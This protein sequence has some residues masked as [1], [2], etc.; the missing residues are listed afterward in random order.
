MRIVEIDR[1]IAL[2]LWAR[3]WAPS[4]NH[5]FE[6]MEVISGLVVGLGSLAIVLPIVG[7]CLVMSAAA[8]TREQI[9]AYVEAGE[10][11]A[12]A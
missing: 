7:P 10:N 2:E 8:I 11:T 1:S 6:T 9:H 12:A 5:G 4:W 3:M